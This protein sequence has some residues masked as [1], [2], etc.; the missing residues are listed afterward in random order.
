[1][2]VLPVFAVSVLVSMPSFAREQVP[3]E[4]IASPAL[5]CPKVSV[6]LKNPDG[7][8]DHVDLAVTAFP[9]LS[10]VAGRISWQA[11][12]ET[13]A[14]KAIKGSTAAAI[15]RSVETPVTYVA[16]ELRLD[17]REKDCD[18]TKHT[19]SVGVTF[20]GAVLPGPMEASP[21][22]Q[23]VCNTS[24]VVTLADAVI[25]ARETHPDIGAA[26]RTLEAAEASR[27]PGWQRFVPL[28]TNSLSQVHSVNYS[29]LGS[30][31]G[32]PPVLS[33]SAGVALPL[34]L[35]N[36]FS[37]KAA[38]LGAKSAAEAVRAAENQIAMRTI[39]AYSAIVIARDQRRLLKVN[40]LGALFKMQDDPQLKDKEQLKAMTG[41]LIANVKSLLISQK[42]ALKT[43]EEQ[44][45]QLTHI[46][47]DGEAPDVEHPDVWLSPFSA[48]G[49]GMPIFPSAEVASALAKAGSPI[50]KSGQYAVA[51][52]KNALRAAQWSPVSASA[53]YGPAMTWAN[54]PAPSPSLYS[55]AENRT[56]GVTVNFDPFAYF[57]GRKAAKQSY[58]AARL[59]ALGQVR[60]VE[61]TVDADFLQYQ[62]QVE[63]ICT[64]K[65]ELVEIVRNFA[66][67]IALI[68]T[69][70]S[71]D[72]LAAV[73]AF[74]PALQAF[75]QVYGAEMT[76]I[77]ALAD[78][79][80]QIGD[81]SFPEKWDATSNPKDVCESAPKP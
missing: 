28:F 73:T 16:P 3:V 32:T 37:W 39:L 44:F 47:L 50:L 69:G 26:R 13:E 59:T 41:T 33:F 42:Y 2:R 68:T 67:L 80:A 21:T 72:P 1:M 35:G 70:K 78:I 71:Y 65:P 57:R 15:T 74:P 14:L 12:G 81:L 24:F 64:Q 20:T 61:G 79:H 49:D 38:D 46:Q 51:Q 23:V 4:E 25:T 40:F 36:W 55:R 66:K 54:L 31:P 19:C 8:I 60:A 6:A 29:S 10:R 58:E 77:L 48:F 11:L 17:T 45:Y 7:S 34:S 27:G 52:A 75:Q 53:S 18:F 56:F 9:S 43:A 22:V 62:Q 63:T 5:F 30:G 76:A